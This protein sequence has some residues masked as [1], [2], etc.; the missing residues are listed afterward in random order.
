MLD[1]NDENNEHD[2]EIDVYLKSL[3]NERKTGR[4]EWI[5]RRKLKSGGRGSTT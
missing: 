3:K 4:K 2:E 1:D 5:S